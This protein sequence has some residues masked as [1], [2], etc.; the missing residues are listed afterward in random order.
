MPVR[1]TPPPRDP[2]G[3]APARRP[4]SVRR[5][6]SLDITWPDGRAA[7]AQLDGCAR[8]LLTPAD[9]GAPRVLA[10]DRLHATMGIERRL[11][12]LSARPGGPRRDAALAGLAGRMAANGLRAALDEALP[13]EREAATPLYLLVDDLFGCGVI[14]QWAWTRWHEPFLLPSLP[15]GSSAQAQARRMAAM[16]N[17]CTGFR[18]GSS[19]L[20]DLDGTRLNATPVAPLVREDDPAGW[21]ALPSATGVAMRRARR[22]DLWIDPAAPHLVQVDAMFQDSATTPEGGR[23]AVHEYTLA[24]VVDRAQGRLRSVRA[25]PRTLPYPEC[26]AAAEQIA[27]LEGLPVRALRVEVLQRLAGPRGCTHLN[28]ALRA[29]AEVPVL[30]ARLQAATG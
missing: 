11:L 10:E 9:G 15:P 7:P 23:V 25:Q 12:S 3:P 13:E 22:I 16:E 14:K 27:V 18:S 5:T 30:A 19:A 29:L 24:A 6:L 4:G 8:D 26:P 2:S 21:H 28:D 20:S 1:L 17:V